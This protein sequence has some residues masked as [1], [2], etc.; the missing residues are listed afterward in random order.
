MVGIWFGLIFFGIPLGLVVFFGN[1]LYRYVSAKRKNMEE[2][3]TF[4]EEE[5][6]KRKTMVIVSAVTAG[7]V[8]AVVVGFLAMLVMAIAYM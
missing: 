5:M 4:P 2:P 6:K 7:V 8:V 3:G 1:C